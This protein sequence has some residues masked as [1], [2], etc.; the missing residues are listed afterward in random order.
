[1][2]CCLHD[3][4]PEDV[5]ALISYAQSQR[6]MNLRET[7]VNNSYGERAFSHIGPKLWNLLPQEITEEHELLKF[8]QKLKTFLMTRGEEFI[9]WTKVR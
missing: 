7:R 8:K 5:A 3:K 9:E 2:Y 4:A 6:T 1:M